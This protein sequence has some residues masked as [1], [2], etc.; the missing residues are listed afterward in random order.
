MTKDKFIILTSAWSRCPENTV[1]PKIDCLLNGF[2]KLAA[3]RYFRD[4]NWE[5][6]C[7]FTYVLELRKLY[8]NQLE[9]KIFNFQ[10]CLKGPRAML[11]FRK[12]CCYFRRL[13]ILMYICFYIYKL[14]ICKSI[15]SSIN[16]I[17]AFIEKLIMSKVAACKFLLLH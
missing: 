4:S 6:Y 8:H 12:K 1:H 13:R 10:R 2:W 15:D 5:Q 9:K 14:Y 7:T 3:T 11:H 16:T 17:N